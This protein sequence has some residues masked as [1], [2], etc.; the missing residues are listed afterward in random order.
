MWTFLIVDYNLI[1]N[2]LSQDIGI[3]FYHLLE[4]VRII[5]DKLVEISDRVLIYHLT[6]QGK[7]PIQELILRDKVWIRSIILY[8]EACKSKSKNWGIKTKQR[9]TAFSSGTAKCMNFQE[10]EMV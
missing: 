6:F 8:F 9:W 10:K 4:T 3:I 2:W 1:L 5:K 7:V